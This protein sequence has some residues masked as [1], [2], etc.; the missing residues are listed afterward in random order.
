MPDIINIL[1]PIQHRGIPVGAAVGGGGLPA[2]GFEC[3]EA[4]LTRETGHGTL[5]SIQWTNIPM[6][7]EAPMDL[8]PFRVPYSWKTREKIVTEVKRLAVKAV[9]DAPPVLDAHIM[10]TFKRVN[11][12]Q[13]KTGKP[14]EECSETIEQ[15]KTELV[16]LRAA[17]D[18]FRTSGQAKNE[19][20]PR[21]SSGGRAAILAARMAREVSDAII[22]EIEAKDVPPAATGAD[23]KARL[24]ASIN[25][26]VDQ[27]EK[28]SNDW[29]Q[30]RVRCKCNN[31][32]TRWI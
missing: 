4:K 30:A 12:L 10:G 17:R 8:V 21:L 3:L 26:I 5:S 27:Y 28:G 2:G 11:T 15:L 24:D 16:Q 6:L 23:A 14:Q 25:A 18:Q 22:D 19:K 9:Y 7:G 13:T 1:G 29:I 32:R 20:I 31:G